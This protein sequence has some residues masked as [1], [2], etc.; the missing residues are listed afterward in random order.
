MMSKIGQIPVD[1]QCRWLLA[2][3]FQKSDQMENAFALNF[4]GKFRLQFVTI[5]LG[6]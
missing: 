6:V 2:F 1:D 5:L 4:V 3:L